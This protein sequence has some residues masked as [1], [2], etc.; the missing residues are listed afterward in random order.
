MSKICAVVITFRGDEFVIESLRSIL[1]HVE[2][3]VFV[4]SEVGWNGETGNTVYPKLLKEFGE[5]NPKIHHI[6]FDST[7]QNKQRAQGV[8]WLEEKNIPFDYIM[9][10]DTDEV[11]GKGF[12]KTMLPILDENLKVKYPARGYTTD[13]IAALKS[14]FYWVSPN[15][16]YHP[17]V[18]IHR[19]AA[20]EIGKSIRG[21]D[22]LRKQ[23][24][25]APLLHF[26]AVRRS[27]TDV[28]TKVEASC[29]AEK[30]DTVPKAIWVA[31]VWNKL[32]YAHD[33][34]YAAQF[35]GAWKGCR[36]VGLEEL[37]KELH[38][39]PIVKAWL[40]YPKPLIRV[41]IKK[42]EQVAS[43]AD[44]LRKHGLPAGFTP[45]HPDYKAMPSRRYK[46]AAYQEELRQLSMDAP[47]EP[48]KLAIMTIVSGNYQWYAPLFL[49]RV[50]KE[51]PGVEPIIIVRN[52]D[53]D[54]EC[55]QYI[56]DS[57]LLKYPDNGYTTAALRFVYEPPNAK[58]FDAVLITD[59]DMLLMAEET[60]IITQHLRSMAKNGLRT[61]DNYVSSITE[62][63]PRCP[64]CHFVTREWWDITRLV[65]EKYAKELME[66]GSPAWWYDESL[67]YKII[68]E[69]GLPEPPK[70]PNLWAH[71]G[72]HLG[73]WRMRVKNKERYS[74]V[75]GFEQS[76]I[77]KL[78]ADKEW[79]DLAAACGE[80]LE[81]LKETIELWRKI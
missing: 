81:G 60:P 54:S 28:W 22:I 1:F 13:W 9:V 68:K 2:H 24:V 4:H 63:Y 47:P 20:G 11:P 5:Q 57:G 38:E 23:Y 40:K 31:Q 56:T 53:K 50:K 41:E 73:D 17:T 75:N 67:I 3:A 62:G 55:G 18:F 32:P 15:S 21:I 7:D 79:M 14:P 36:E 59:I 33:L 52:A 16:D 39:N 49:N 43:N 80:H 8:Q 44:L 51:L 58:D 48:Q 76:Y 25:P 61:Y 35:R 45:D 6:I 77:R 78:L 37:P 65:R 72:I 74:Q 26:T 66:K 12:W 29:K 27:L 10:I 30:L 64:G 69:S 46:W 42:P 71:H 34:H 70:Q 19:D